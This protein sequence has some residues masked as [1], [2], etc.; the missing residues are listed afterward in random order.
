MRD[1]VEHHSETKPPYIDEGLVIN[2]RLSEVERQQREDKEADKK[3]NRSQ[4]ITNQLLAVFTGFLF[5][6]SVISD[7]ILFRQTK[8]TKES[9]DAAKSAAETADKTLGLMKSSS[10]ETTDQ[11]ERLIK[12]QQRTAGAMET[13]VRQSIAVMQ[14][15]ERPYMAVKT[16]EL[17]HGTANQGLIASVTFENVGKSLANIK[18]IYRVAES[19]PIRE[20]NRSAFLATAEELFKRSRADV[21][22]IVNEP[23]A[24]PPGGTPGSSYQ[25]LFLYEPMF[26]NSLTANPPWR[27]FFTGSIVYSDIWGA[28]YETEFC[29]LLPKGKGDLG[30]RTCGVHNTIRIRAKDEKP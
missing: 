25:L 9:A 24:I 28:E 18:R 13:N 4:L 14:L 8:A 7:T 29:V 26:S 6:T 12:Q 16:V 17:T 20:G 22:S 11:I 3:H 10:Q 27:I 5:V 15:D 23:Q 19:R 30:P 21:D 2:T 1:D